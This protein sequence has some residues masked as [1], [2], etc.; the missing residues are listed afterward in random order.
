MARASGAG[1]DPDGSLCWVADA[2]ALEVFSCVTGFSFWRARLA[3]PGHVDATV[4]IAWRAGELLVH[5]VGPRRDHLELRDAGTGLLVTHPSARRARA[6]ARP[7]SARSRRRGGRITDRRS[8]QWS[9]RRRDHP[10][11]RRR[12]RPRPRRLPP[13]RGLTCSPSS[14]IA[15]KLRARGLVARRI[16]RASDR[17]PPRDRARR[18][19]AGARARSVGTGAEVVR[20]LVGAG[21]ERPR[22]RRAPAGRALR[23]RPR[24]GPPAA[25]V[26]AGRA[27]ALTCARRQPVPGGRAG[28]SRGSLSL[29][30]ACRRRWFRC[31]DD[32]M[33]AS[34]ACSRR[35][36]GALR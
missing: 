4:H 29:A 19:S 20:A 28:R 13:D 36:G 27:G 12:A 17:G 16:A 25:S 21:H 9:P 8:R 24:T 1:V 35:T 3:P 6:A 30:I 5:R 33:S 34:R 23:R 7:A 32:S 31:T 14:T 11:S 10:A 26:S 15:A 22:S 2:E 18:S